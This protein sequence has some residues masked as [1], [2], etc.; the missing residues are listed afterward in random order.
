MVFFKKLN[1]NF[2]D[3]LEPLRQSKMSVGHLKSGGVQTESMRTPDGLQVDNHETCSFDCIVGGVHLESR[4]PS[5]VHLESNR[6]VWRSVKYT[7]ENEI[8]NEIPTNE[9]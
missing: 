7:M 8:L 3:Q 9:Q 1:L 2:V 5:G 6:N 4:Y